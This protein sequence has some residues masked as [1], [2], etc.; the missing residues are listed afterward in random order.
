[1]SLLFSAICNVSS[2][3]HFAF[4]HFFSPFGMVWSPPSIQCYESVCSSSA[5]LSAR[6][7]PLSLLVI[8][9]VKSWGIWFKS[10]L[11]GLVVFPTFLNLSLNFAIRISWSW[12]AVSSRSYFCWLYRTFP[13]FPSWAAKNIINVI[14][15]LTIW[16]CQCVELSLVLLEENVCYDQFSFDKTLMAFSLLHFVIQ[17]QSSCYFRYLLTSYFCI[18]IPYNE[19]DIFFV[20]SSRRSWRSS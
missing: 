16:W 15:I 4:L 6:S 3:N 9:T 17:S 11:N 10:Y 2:G 18:P 19:K 13:S 1:M 5:T 7:N 12:V 14:S 8:S 20:V